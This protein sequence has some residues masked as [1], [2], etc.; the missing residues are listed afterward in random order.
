[1]A[2]YVDRF[3]VPP[4]VSFRLESIDPD[5]RGRSGEGD[6]KAIE[7]QRDRDLEQ[8]EHLQYRLYAENNRALLVVL[9]ATDS[10]GKD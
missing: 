7:A 10:G 2:I 5:D 3:L 1:M 6:R 9:L 8:L 4:G